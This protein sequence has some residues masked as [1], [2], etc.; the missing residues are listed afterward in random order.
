MQNLA[1]GGLIAWQSAQV[2]PNGP[3]HEAHQRLD[4][5]TGV[6]HKEQHGTAMSASF[7]ANDNGSVRI[8]AGPVGAVAAAGRRR[9]TDGNQ[10]WTLTI[11]GSP[12]ANRVE[13]NEHCILATR[14][15]FS[16]V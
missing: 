4:P 16:Y 10:A 3:L 9:S 1:L 15:R 6:L 5:S 12:V 13:R 8:E 11:A 14:R 2:A 7:L